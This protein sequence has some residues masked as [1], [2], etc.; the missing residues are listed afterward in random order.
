MAAGVFGWMG[1]QPWWA[2]WMMLTALLSLFTSKHLCQALAPLF[3]LPSSA[4]GILP[5]RAVT[6]VP[7][8][9]RRDHCRATAY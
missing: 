6:S 7:P 9:C 5:G 4:S 1:G 8:A 2:C 3:W